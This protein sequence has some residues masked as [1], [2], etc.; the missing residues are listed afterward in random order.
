MKFEKGDRITR[1][2]TAVLHE[3]AGGVLLFRDPRSNHIFVA[4][5][6]TE[7]G[8]YVLPKGHLHGKEIPEQ[9]AAR[10]IKEELSLPRAPRLR[11]RVGAT[12]YQ[13]AVP[14]D[15]RV[16]KKK[17]HWFIFESYEKETL[18]PLKK[19]GFVAAR[20]MPFGEATK[21]ATY[22][23]REI[24]RAKSI[25]DRR[26]MNKDI[27]RV[28]DALAEV[29]RTAKKSLGTNLVG[30]IFEG[31]GARGSY[32]HGWSD[33]DV[34]LVLE[35][36]DTGAKRRIGSLIKEWEEKTGI[37]HGVNVVTAR[38]I[39]RPRLPVVSLDG[40]TLQALLELKRHPER[41]VYLKSAASL[42]FYVP[43]PRDIKEY[44][45]ANIGMFARKNRRDLT[46]GNA[47]EKEL[48]RTEI[49]AAFTM[50]KLALQA[51]GAY[52]E[53]EELSTQARKTFSAFDSAFL[54]VAEGI[55]RHWSTYNDKR[56]ISAALARADRFLEEFSEYV[57]EKASRTS[58]RR[59]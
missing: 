6:K 40:K 13:F 38:E 50:V 2:K 17:V 48:L 39:T 27:S 58:S 37:H 15:K 53:S 24:V 35:K 55:I 43:S 25:F 49:R 8:E 23:K 47:G 21:K 14:G 11:G 51:F 10:E 31:S 57:Y 44:S 32:R 56:A 20:W 45:I 7:S 41:L 22:S 18:A 19:E 33:V 26:R 59:A 12:Q 42:R 16:H 46:M 30:I 54:K 29:V 9:S 34:L 1:T 28:D 36:I 52:S 5:L 4:L 3:S